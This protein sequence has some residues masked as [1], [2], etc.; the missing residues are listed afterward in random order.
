MRASRMRRRR[1]PRSVVPR[2]PCRPCRS[3]VPSARGWRLA[4]SCWTMPVN[5]G[6]DAA[7]SPSVLYHER[8]IT[9]AESHSIGHVD[10]RLRCLVRAPQQH[11]LVPPR[12]P[13]RPC[14][15]FRACPRTSPRTRRPTAD[16]PSLKYASTNASL[17]SMAMIGAVVS[18][19]VKKRPATSRMFSASA[20]PGVITECR[21]VATSGSP[22][23]AVMPGSRNPEL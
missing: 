11:V 6:T 19:V 21:A 5:N 3:K 2:R 23:G 17:T 18:S 9:N 12:P 10:L 7:G 13:R 22:S 16:R 1:T 15:P 8:G 4:S 20:K 14:R